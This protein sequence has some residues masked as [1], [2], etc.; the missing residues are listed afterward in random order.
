MKMKT[1]KSDGLPISFAHKLYVADN[2]DAIIFNKKVESRWQLKDF[3]NFAKR[4]DTLSQVEMQSG[5]RL[6]F[7]PTNKVRFPIDKSAVIASMIVN[8]AQNDSIVP[9]IDID[10]KG[11]A[12]YKNRLIMFDILNNNN[13]KRPIYF[14]PGSFGDDDY[15]WMK[16]YLQMDGMVYKLV[17][18]KTKVNEDDYP[19]M[20]Q[21]DTEKMYNL[22]MKW[23]W[24]NGESTKIYHDPETRRN[25]I[26]YRTNLSRLMTELIAEGKNQKAKKVIDLALAKTPIDY[27]GYYLTL[28]PFASGYYEIGEK[29]KA[30]ELIKKL[31]TK[32]KE[33]LKYFS[34]FKSS[35]QTFMATDIV[36]AI[37]R[38]RS[39][40]K[41]MKKEGDIEFYNANR[42]QFNS[43]NNRFPRFD[44][45]NE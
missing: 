41:V 28:E 19:D 14:S 25:A 20:G 42:G 40:L 15:L 26:S 27:Y 29:V 13:W 33:E 9:F 11:G 7:F 16:D 8:P 10:I 6:N 35:D 30:R 5:H 23:E 12:L 34:T 31:M 17:P 1:Y 22:A 44:R 43:Y 18:I 38:Y 24:G 4:E 36:T 3:I 21:L 2:R 32:Y 37:E 45:E 39:L